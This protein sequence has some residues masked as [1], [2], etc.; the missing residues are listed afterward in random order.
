MPRRTV[1]GILWSALFCWAGGV[2]WLSSL[3]P[4]Q[5]PDGAFVFGDKF[6]HFIAFVIGGW[7]A[8]SALRM[9]R[10]RATVAGQIVLA[11]IIVA[12]FGALDESLQTFTPGRAGGD[13]Y[14]WFADFL[15]AGVG[16]LLS[17]VTHE[18]LERRVLGRLS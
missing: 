1:A 2:F 17:L 13:V 4:K 12:V 5:L 6:A 3:T 7:L 9:S 15:G 8:A 14:D 10:P 18:R 16:A 11:V